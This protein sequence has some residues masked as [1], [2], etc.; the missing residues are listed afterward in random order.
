MPAIKWFASR[1]DKL[2]TGTPRSYLCCFSW[3]IGYI[4]IDRHP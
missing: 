3:M 4:E 1:F 2:R